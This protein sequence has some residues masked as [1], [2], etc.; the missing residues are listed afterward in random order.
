MISKNLVSQILVGVLIWDLTDSS[1]FLKI[2][3]KNFLL[4]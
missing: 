1:L 4:R 2:I 3:Y